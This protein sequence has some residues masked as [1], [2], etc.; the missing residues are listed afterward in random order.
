MGV[1]E[2]HQ[3]KVHDRFQYSEYARPTCANSTHV[4]HE[5]YGLRVW[6]I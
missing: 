3:G 5:Q 4:A 6:D 1:S 2:Y